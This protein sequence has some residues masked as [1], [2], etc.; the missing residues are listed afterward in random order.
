[1]PLLVSTFTVFYIFLVGSDG[2]QLY[3]GND[4]ALGICA[5]FPALRGMEGEGD[6]RGAELLETLGDS[7]SPRLCVCVTDGLPAVPAKP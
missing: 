2:W 5:L 6:F 4:V 1:M 3:P 7:E